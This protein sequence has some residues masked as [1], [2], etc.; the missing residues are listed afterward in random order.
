MKPAAL[1]HHRLRHDGAGASAQHRPFCRCRAWPRSS[2]PT[3]DMRAARS[4]AG[5]GAR[6]VGSV[7]EVLAV[8]RGELPADRQPNHL[9]LGQLEE[10]A[11]HPPAAGAGAKSRCSPTR[12]MRRGWQP[13]A[14]A[15]RRR[16]GW[17]WNTATCRP[18]P[19]CIARGAG[20]DR[21]RQDADDPRTPLS[22]PAKGRRLEPLQPQLPAARW[23]KSAAI[24]S[25]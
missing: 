12:P 6:M 13:C 5:P 8:D 16:S 18:S 4:G 10:I 9:H 24:S 17:R 15:T 23:W 22:L 1:R 3:P 21:R 14:P 7:A 19:I 25:T 2:N 20:G 11:A